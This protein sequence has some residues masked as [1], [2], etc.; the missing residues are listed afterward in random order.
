MKKYELVIK[1][2]R[3]I[4]NKVAVIVTLQDKERFAGEIVDLNINM[5]RVEGAT[6]EFY[7]AEAI[8]RAKT[9]FLDVAEK[10]CEEE[11]LQEKRLRS[12]ARYTIKINSNNTISSAK[13]DIESRIEQLECYISELKKSTPTKDEVL[14]LDEMKETILDLAARLSCASRSKE[15]FQQP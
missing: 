8:K 9:L 6:L 14:A 10:L 2:T 3:N 13:D 15:H 11:A 12:E 5:D 1:G 4:E 7:E